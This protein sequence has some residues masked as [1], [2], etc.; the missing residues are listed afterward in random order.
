[1]N[2]WIGMIGKQINVSFLSA[3]VQFSSVDS[4]AAELCPRGCAE[5]KPHVEKI[6]LTDAVKRLG[7]VKLGSIYIS[8]PMG[9]IATAFHRTG[10]R[11]D[12][13]LWWNMFY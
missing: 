8:K 2:M 5:D 12:L 13:I 10:I 11:E 1:M 3:V 4:G 7:G 9:C 6:N